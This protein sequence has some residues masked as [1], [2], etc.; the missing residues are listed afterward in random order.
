M[1]TIDAILWGW[2]TLPLPQA[3]R[4]P[5]QCTQGL[6]G[7]PGRMEPSDFWEEIGCRTDLKRKKSNSPQ[8]G[9]CP[10]SRMWSNTAA[11]QISKRWNGFEFN[12]FVSLGVGLSASSRRVWWRKDSSRLPGIAV[13][14]FD[15]LFDV[16]A[17][18]DRLPDGRLAILT[19]ERRWRAGTIRRST[20]PEDSYFRDL[21]L[22]L[23]LNLKMKTN[24]FIWGLLDLLAL[25]LHLKVFVWAA[26]CLITCK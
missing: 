11:W 26:S 7:E 21:K 15:V 4:A 23:T 5:P 2:L 10:L 24:P 25:L 9:D 14:A 17:S 22:T 18:I 1:P 6:R 12:I 20:F 19:G 13:T 16:F 3:H 8:A